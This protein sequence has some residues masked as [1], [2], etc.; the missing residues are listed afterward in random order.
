MYD[1]PPPVHVNLASHLERVLTAAEAVR[2]GIATHAQKHEADRTARRERLTAEA[3]VTAGQ[4]TR[5]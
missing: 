2:A 1:I 4:V 3:R 5:A